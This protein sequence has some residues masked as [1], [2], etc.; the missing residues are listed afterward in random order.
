MAAHQHRGHQREE[1]AA[2][3]ADAQERSVHWEAVSDGGRR[4]GL[5]R[6]YFAARPTVN[7]R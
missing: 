6:V 5:L 4:K 7:M 3:H 2:R 1:Q